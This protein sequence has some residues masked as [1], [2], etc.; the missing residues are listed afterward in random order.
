MEIK[1]YVSFSFI[2]RLHV[3]DLKTSSFDTIDISRT[4]TLQWINEPMSRLGTTDAD[5]TQASRLPKVP[6]KL[7]YYE[8]LIKNP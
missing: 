5:R 7:K 3:I 1:L 6:S 4:Q 2:S 8:K